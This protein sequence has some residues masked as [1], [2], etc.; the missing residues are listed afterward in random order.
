MFSY[1]HTLYAYLLNDIAVNK[2]IHTSLGLTLQSTISSIA[3]A[4]Y[5]AKII[6]ESL[7]LPES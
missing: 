4:E 2:M 5:A 7:N 6:E 1:N 3:N